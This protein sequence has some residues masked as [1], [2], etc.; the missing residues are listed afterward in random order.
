MNEKTG[1]NTVVKGYLNSKVFS[2]S[3][4]PGSFTYENIKSYGVSSYGSARNGSCSLSGGSGRHTAV[5]IASEYIGVIFVT[6]QI[7]FSA[8]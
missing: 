6:G 1:D 7:P 4:N 2:V 3:G 5:I 8:G